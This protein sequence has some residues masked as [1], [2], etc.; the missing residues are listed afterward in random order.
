MTAFASIFLM[1]G[2]AKRNQTTGLNEDKRS[3]KSLL[4]RVAGVSAVW[5][6][7]AGECR[8]SCAAELS[9]PTGRLYRQKHDGD[10]VPESKEIS[11]RERK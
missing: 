4:E 2:V 11:R 8:A 5:M 6:H 1:K 7:K 3:V 9:L 10:V